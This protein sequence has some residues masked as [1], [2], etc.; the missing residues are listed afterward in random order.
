MIFRKEIEFA[1]NDYVCECCRIIWCLLSLSKDNYQ[2]V[3]YPTM[4]DERKK[5][6]KE[7]K[8]KIKIVDM[9]FGID[10]YGDFEDI[11]MDGTESAIIVNNELVKI[12]K[13]EEYDEK[14]HKREMGSVNN[15]KCIKFVSWPAIVKVYVN[16]NEDD[17]EKDKDKGKDGGSGLFGRLNDGSDK[18]D[19]KQNKH[20]FLTRA[21]VFCCD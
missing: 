20:E 10:N 7:K 5:G 14:I 17:E 21:F 8:K 1:L 18:N 15:G 11:K 16:E 2:Y 9:E 12:K 19:C 3:L 13:M 4:F 6:K